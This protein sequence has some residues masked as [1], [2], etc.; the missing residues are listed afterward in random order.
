MIFPANYYSKHLRK[1]EA[2]FVVTV[3]S[4][5]KKILPKLDREFAR[6]C[7]IDGGLPMLKKNLRSNMERELTTVLNSQ[8]KRKLINSLTDNNKLLLPEEP[9]KR[10]AQYLLEQE[11]NNLNNHGV[12]V[13][14]IKLDSNDFRDLAKRRVS[15][16]LLISKIIHDNAIKPDED[17]VQAVIDNIATKNEKPEDIVKLY[18]NNQEKLLEIQMMVVEEQVIEWIY[19]HVKVEESIS[20]FSDVMKA[21]TMT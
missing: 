13:D 14:L 18:K 5:A 21:D 12:N 1:K 7:G 8:N 6:L 20:T 10:E 3:K 16:S 4:V 17:R 19:E 11:R 2:Y 9:I 15:F